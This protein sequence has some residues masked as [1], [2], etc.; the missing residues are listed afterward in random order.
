MYTLSRGHPGEEAHDYGYNL[1]KLRRRSN[2]SSTHGH[3]I[4]DFKTKFEA[5]DPDPVFEEET[6]GALPDSDEPEFGVGLKKHDTMDS[7]SGGS[8]E[9]EDAAAAMKGGK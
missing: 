7:V 6:M 5:V 4:T 9:E 2:S 3:A 8:V 1:T